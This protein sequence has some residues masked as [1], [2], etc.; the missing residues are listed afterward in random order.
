MYN[1]CFFRLGETVG[2]STCGDAAVAGR[3]KGHAV[4]VVPQGGEAQE[5][6]WLWRM[7]VIGETLYLYEVKKIIK[8]HTHKT[9]PYFK[10]ER[11]KKQRSQK[12][13]WLTCM[14]TG[15]CIGVTFRRSAGADLG[16]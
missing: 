14:G 15:M 1:H 12:C 9:M 13:L 3:S 16:R 10:K 2:G 7:L 4:A 5:V 8:N 11:T 6:H